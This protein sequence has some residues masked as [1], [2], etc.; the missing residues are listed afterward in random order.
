[1]LDRRPAPLWR[2]HCGKMCI[3]GLALN[4]HPLFPFILVS[5]RDEFPSRRTTDPR[6]LENGLLCGV[7][8]KSQGTW[9][10]FNTQ[11][12]RLAAVTNCGGATT[13]QSRGELVRTFLTD[14]ADDT[15]RGTL[16]KYNGFNLIFS[17]LWGACP[18]LV[19]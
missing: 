3:I 10:G 2:L 16:L 18:R 15:R 1:M 6:V 13:A 8:H 5:N 9:L 19:L 4:R 14:P 12:G 11:T 17:D 7:D